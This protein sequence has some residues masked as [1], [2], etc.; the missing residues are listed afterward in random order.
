M[1]QVVLMEGGSGPTNEEYLRKSQPPKLHSGLAKLPSEE[2][3]TEC[4]RC[5]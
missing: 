4:Y 1:V 5:E 2:V 3:K